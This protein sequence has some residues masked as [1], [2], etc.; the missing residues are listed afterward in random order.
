MS[1][2][3]V[4]L[5]PGAAIGCVV[6]I[7]VAATLHWAFPSQDILVAQAFIVTVCCVVGLVIEHKFDGTRRKDE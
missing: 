6:G 2:V 4:I 3:D 1:I 7:G 5:N